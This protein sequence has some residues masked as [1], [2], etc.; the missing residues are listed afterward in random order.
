M[1]NHDRRA[2]LG[3]ALALTGGALLLADLCRL[4]KNPAATRQDPLIN[5]LPRGITL[6]SVSRGGR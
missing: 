1:T 5:A 4:L 3:T 6:R 2:A